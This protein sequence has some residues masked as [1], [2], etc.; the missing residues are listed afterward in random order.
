MRRRKLTQGRG[1]RPSMYQGAEQVAVA[2]YF[3]TFSLAVTS[4]V[5]Y[6]TAWYADPGGHR[7]DYP[8]SHRTSARLCG[9][10]AGVNLVVAVVVHL[11]T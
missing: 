10:A 1:W 11:A 4:L 8:A 7:S 3:T 2:L 6:A 9:F 5:Q